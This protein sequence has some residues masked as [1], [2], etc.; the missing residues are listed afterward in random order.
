MRQNIRLLPFLV[1]ALFVG[2][3]S[4]ISQQTI[5][6]HPDSTT[7]GG[8]LQTVW[9]Q[10]H[11]FN[12]RCPFDT[13]RQKRSLAGCVAM[14]MAQ[15]I[16]YH[17]DS[18]RI[19]NFSDSDNYTSVLNNFSFRVDQ[20]CGTYNTLKWA[21]L[22]QALAGIQY[23]LRATSDSGLV[24]E[25]VYS[26]GI[27]VQTSYSANY[28]QAAE[29]KMPAAL[30]SCFGF[31]TAEQI[32]GSDSTILANLQWCLKNA[33]PVIVTL[34]RSD[35]APHVVVVDGF[36]EMGKGPQ[37]DLYHVNY[38]GAAPGETFWASF[39]PPLQFNSPINHGFN[40][41]RSIIVSSAAPMPPPP[42]PPPP[43]PPKA[44]F[45]AKPLKGW[46]WLYVDF[47]NQCTGTVSQW[48]WD[49]GDGSVHENYPNPT[50][51]YRKAG[52]YSVTLIATGP[53]GCDSLTITNMIT[54]Y[55]TPV[56]DTGVQIGFG[57]SGTAAWGDMDN[58]GDLDLLGV[59][60]GGLAMYRN[61]Q[62]RL[63]A[64]N[65][66]SS[67][68]LISSAQWL[69]PDR[70]NDL[71]LILFSRTD[72]GE[73]KAAFYR[74][75]N[76]RFALTDFQLP[77]IFYGGPSWG[78]YDND[79]DLDMAAVTSRTSSGLILWQNSPD[80]FIKTFTLPNNYTTTGRWCD[81][82]HDQDLD[83]LNS[84]N[85]LFRNTNGRFSTEQLPWSSNSSIHADDYD[86][87]K[88][89]DFLISGYDATCIYLNTGDITKA[90]R[91][92]VSDIKSGNAVWL[93]YNNDG[94][95]DILLAGSNGESSQHITRLYYGQESGFSQVTNTP[96]DEISSQYVAV[97]DYN[98]DL[99]PDLL[100]RGDIYNS[101]GK[102][103]LNNSAAPA[104]LPDAPQNLTVAVTGHVAEFS[105]SAPLHKDLTFNLSVGT[106]PGSCDILS[107]LSIRSSGKRLI[108]VSGNVWNNRQW[109]LR[110]PAGDYYWTVQAVDVNHNG[111]AFAPEQHFTIPLSN[112][113]ITATDS[114]QAE[115]N[116]D[117]IMLTWNHVQ[118][119]EVYRYH[120]YKNG[121]KTATL[122]GNMPAYLDADV[123]QGQHYQY[124]LI[125][126]NWSYLSSTPSETVVVAYQLPFS[127]ITT[128]IPA[129]SD[130]F[131]I[132]DVDNDGDMDILERYEKYTTGHSIFLN[133]AGS[134]TEKKLY[135]NG[136]WS[137]N[138]S[139]L[140]YDFDNDNDLDLIYSFSLSRHFSFQFLRNDISKFSEITFT[141]P[142]QTA[143]HGSSYLFH[144]DID[145]DGRQDI[146]DNGLEE[147]T[148]SSGMVCAGKSVKN[149]GNGWQ[150]TTGGALSDYLG[151]Y[152]FCDYDLDGD[153]DILFRGYTG[154]YDYDDPNRA[155]LLRL[156]NNHRGCFSLVDSSVL[157]WTT[158]SIKGVPA[159]QDWDHDGDCDITI[160]HDHVLTVYYNDNGRFTGSSVTSQESIPILSCDINNDG[161]QDVLR[162]ETVKYNIYLQTDYGWQP[163][164]SFPFELGGNPRLFDYDVDGDLDILLANNSGGYAIL[165][166]ND[167]ENRIAPPPAP[168]NLVAMAGQDSVI[169]TWE[170]STAA[171]HPADFSYNLRVGSTPGGCDIVSPLADVKTGQRRILSQGN[172]LSGKIWK[173][174]GLAAGTYYWSVQTIDPGHLGGPFAAE[175]SFTIGPTS[176][177]AHQEQSIQFALHQNHPNPFNSQTEIR[178]DLP[179]P[180][181]V[182]LAIYNLSGQV[183]ALLVEQKMAAGE[184]VCN[185]NGETSEN[186]LVAS[187]VYLYRLQA[188]DFTRTR[189]LAVIH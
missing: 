183:V 154:P 97:A 39:W 105:W 19:K 169:M 71:D 84:Y 54:V 103:F 30:R 14:A 37:D 79:G 134:Y 68:L 162:Y 8:W 172:I 61:D 64:V 26:A 128:D 31:T 87:D 29:G 121:K 58:D 34:T 82:D 35:D 33:L 57:D 148:E 13:V 188:G 109:R 51:C 107:P 186:K 187:G 139:T 1:I 6:P 175:Q 93:D 118:P 69:D 189:K 179:S 63:T 117:H 18:T 4:S 21:Q 11:P 125:A 178:F 177:V 80:G 122:D 119:E 20:D 10:E 36:N 168:V 108:P 56:I 53:K 46:P 65:I 23:P 123:A 110:L 120:L 145:N 85:T 155:I 181:R 2:N 137:R 72:S 90:V 47:I 38:G 24:D 146:L 141:G 101:T 12:A 32:I 152:S 66:V 17:H 44:K 83:L 170:E 100:T 86:R 135:L 114:L 67:N 185:W 75:N 50:H 27:S 88:D 55:D 41:I 89:L 124:Y 132:A 184:H 129:T 133:T 126:E 131:Q 98:Q 9:H 76:G 43:T 92:E 127:R 140:L 74:N 138:A 160:R 147:L 164:Y 130:F 94:R 62:G 143:F 144:L 157:A 176:Q 151:E 115:K 96:L 49:F 182:R 60:N 45:V 106:T 59:N 7:T 95:T 16:H 158:D 48:D 149:T 167:T 156:F 163:Y 104:V 78:D 111:S 91:S 77:T 171:R 113:S 153:Q 22:N 142:G 70:D 102:L 52:Q 165:L 112:E 15:L 136:S 116:A 166:R 81:V 25:L 3:S 73:Y 161:R 28:S 180:A 99:K 173:L 150:L 40:K 159:W 174:Y 42:P 5:W